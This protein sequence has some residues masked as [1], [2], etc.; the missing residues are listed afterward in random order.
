MVSV[1]HSF[2][3]SIPIK[4]FVFSYSFLQ[5][6]SGLIV[7]IGIKCSLSDKK[8]ALPSSSDTSTSSSSRVRSITAVN[9][10]LQVVDTGSGCEGLRE[11]MNPWRL[12]RVYKY[13]RSL[14]PEIIV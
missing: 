3:G 5:V 1:M 12:F 10:Y 4:V 11:A 9:R 6:L 2:I 8:V 7:K 14:N 13:V